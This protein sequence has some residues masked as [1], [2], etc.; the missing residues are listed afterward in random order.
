MI[1]T[2]EVII[3][4]L[5]FIT[6]SCTKTADMVINT[7]MAAGIYLLQAATHKEMNGTTNGNPEMEGDTVAVENKDVESY[8]TK[9]L[10]TS[11]R[12]CCFYRLK[13][14]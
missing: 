1:K 8:F 2:E 14:I 12:W 3:M 5:L 11:V 13:S 6:N 10:S 4:D 9:P 7:M